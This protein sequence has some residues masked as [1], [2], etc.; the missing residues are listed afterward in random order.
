MMIHGLKQT[1]KDYEANA[2][3][4]YAFTQALNDDFSCVINCKSAYEVWNDLITTHEGTLQVKRSKID[5]FCSQYKNFYMLEHESIDE[6]LTQFTK[7][8]NGLSSLGD[9]I[10][11]DQK[12]ASSLELSPKLRKS[13]R[14]P[15][16]S[17]MI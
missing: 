1:A 15:S 6:T 5:L 4:Q 8:T 12:F 9:T 3:A 10:D 17:L 13:R 16:R 14:Q 7:I 11:N 2:K